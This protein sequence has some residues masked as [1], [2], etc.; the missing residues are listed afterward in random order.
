MFFRSHW[1]RTARFD[2]LRQGLDDWDRT[3]GRN[4]PGYVGIWHNQD[5]DEPDFR[6][7]AVETYDVRAFRAGGV[8][9]LQQLIG[10]LSEHLRADVRFVDTQEVHHLSRAD[11]PGASLDLAYHSLWVVTNDIPRLEK[12]VTAWQQASIE[13][14]TL[15]RT[16]LVRGISDQAVH[17][18]SAE[19]GSV[20]T[21]RTVGERAFQELRELL[22]RETVEVLEDRNLYGGVENRSR[23]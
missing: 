11:A 3:E 23:H 5:L 21:L 2:Q 9:A 12:K 4:V 1:T 7:V 17:S 15:A 19:F 6:W 8:P 20:E 14:G 16:W 18:I 22:R 13:D 10:I